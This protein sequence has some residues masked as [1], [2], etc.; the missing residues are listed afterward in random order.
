MPSDTHMKK[1]LLYIP[2]E[3]LYATSYHSESM[4][5]AILQE[6]FITAEQILSK[7]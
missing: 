7:E 3:E 4:Q 5:G 6:C 2:N 1:Y